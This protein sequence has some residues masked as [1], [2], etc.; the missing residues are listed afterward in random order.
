MFR[1]DANPIRRQRR[2]MTRNTGTALHR[3]TRDLLVIDSP[4]LVITD[5]NFSVFIG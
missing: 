5:I 4:L 1:I 3:I 2:I